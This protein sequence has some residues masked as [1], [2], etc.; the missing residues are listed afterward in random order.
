M[1]TE[2]R[3]EIG[4]VKPS[5]WVN[6]KYDST[7]VSGG[8]LY[9]RS[10]LIG[11]Q[12]TGENANERNLITGT[13][14]FN[15]EG[16]LPFENMV[17]DYLKE[18][19]SCHV[20]YRVTPL[21]NGNDLVAHGVQMEAYSVEDAGESICFNVYIYNVQPGISIDY[22]TGESWLNGETPVVNTEVVEIYTDSD[23]MA[24]TYVLNTSSK[25]FHKPSCSS[26][27]DMNE[28]NKQNYHG[29][30]DDL[31]SDGYVACGICKP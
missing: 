1:P 14:Y 19:P 2:P 21:Y 15:V 10:H 4:S 23:G 29:T 12:L 13:R 27:K 24:I 16:M 31:I 26:A 7:L 25:R 8:Y 20:M 3:E 18:E 30:R 9:N 6:K 17:A 22:A 5:G 28:K 11:F